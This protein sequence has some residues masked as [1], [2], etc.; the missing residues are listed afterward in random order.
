MNDKGKI[1]AGLI[2]FVG[3]FTF[4]FYSNLGKASAVPEPLLNTPVIKQMPVKQCVETKEYMRANHMQMLNEW[5]DML[6]RDGIKT[7]KSK[8][9]GKEYVISL[10]N[11]CLNCH[12]NKKDFC[13]TC[14][15]YLAVHPYCWDCHFGPKETGV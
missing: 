10:Q 9:N 5:R 14:H 4:P 15:K 3:I 11:T 8:S 13:D 7:Y 6:L 1:M 2:I 12:S